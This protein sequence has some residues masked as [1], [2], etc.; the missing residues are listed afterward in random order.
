MKAGVIGAVGT[1][2]LTIKKLNKHGFDIV[3]VL[4][5]EPRNREN[6][7]GLTDLRTLSTELGLDF[8]G[9]IKI[10]VPDNVN[11]M[12]ERNPDIIFAV[13]FSQLLSQVWLDMPRLGC[14]GFH[15]T[16]LPKG[17]GRAPI[18]WMILEREAWGAANFFL[19]DEGA[20][21]GP[22]FVQ[23]PYSI[24]EEDDAESLGIKL[25]KAIEKALDRW[26]PKLKSGIW[27]PIPQNEDIATYFGKREPV[28]G[29]IKWDHSSA[30]I[31]RLIKATTRPHPGAYSFLGKTLIRI[32]KSQEEKYLKIKGVTGR[33]LMKK[34]EQLLVQCGKGLLWLTEYDYPDKPLPKV[35]QKLG[36]D[37]E[38]ELFMLMNQIELL[39]KNDK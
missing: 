4:G 37:L 14:I 9:F 22:I 13:G 15:P 35:G 8:R 29:M 38:S 34:E 24:L 18:A 7:A 32:W 33:I 2:A 19:M 10:N 23:E 30:D 17:R 11:W 25:K 39:N 3:G 6:V 12:Q 36:L 1:T 31:D 27:N 21:S 26:L 5:H 20:D 16:L 28:D